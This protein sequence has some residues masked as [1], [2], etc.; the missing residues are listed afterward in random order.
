LV[1]G[2]AAPRQQPEAVPEGRAGPAPAPANA[3]ANGPAFT[4][5]VLDLRIKGFEWRSALQG[6]ANRLDWQNGATVW[7]IESA[8]AD[9]LRSAANQSELGQVLQAPTVQAKAGQ[10]VRTMT[11]STLDLVVGRE[12]RPASSNVGFRPVVKRLHNGLD[13][14]MSAQPNPDGP[15][16]LIG[17]NLDETR[18]QQNHGVSVDGQRPPKP[19]SGSTDDDR[20]GL[21]LFK[22]F[23]RDQDK[24][25]NKPKSSKKNQFAYQVP[26][27]A[28][29]H[30][31]GYWPVPS[32]RAL[33]ISLGARS[34]SPEPGSPPVVFERLVLIRAR[35][36]S[37][38]PNRSEPTDSQ[39][40][41]PPVPGMAR[42]TGPTRR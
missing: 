22:L 27:I 13:I 8:L 39:R 18:V 11:G 36:A 23:Q 30:V 6:R 12:P 4:F 37:A 3:S 33:L 41:T 35:P 1:I 31:E 25:K 17:V 32:N 2:L 38:V 5:E 7:A 29:S 26:E 20:N 24:K 21:G 42:P 34:P 9:R 14:A 16:L 28:Q 40:P 10:S 15:G 19:E